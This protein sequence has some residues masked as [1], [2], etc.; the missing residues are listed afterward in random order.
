MIGI[1]FNPRAAS[2]RIFDESTWSEHF[3]LCQ[4]VNYKLRSPIEL[5]LLVVV[6]FLCIDF[7]AA[8]SVL[9]ILAI[10]GGVR[11]DYVWCG[12]G[13]ICG[14]LQIYRDLFEEARAHQTWLLF[15]QHSAFFRVRDGSAILII[16]QICRI[17]K[18]DSL[19][20]ILRLFLQTATSRIGVCASRVENEFTA[21]FLRQNF[22]GSTWEFT[23]DAQFIRCF[24]L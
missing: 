14:C 17:E 19:L 11:L 13:R 12:A 20:L 7:L 21:S 22:A 24:L 2:V 16:G 8:G 10:R 1:I 5:L 18:F 3:F 9:R 4:G 15:V 6:R 23:P